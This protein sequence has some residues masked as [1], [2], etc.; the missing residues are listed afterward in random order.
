VRALLGGRQIGQIA[1]QLPV[2]SGLVDVLVENQPEM[3]LAAAFVRIG[4]R[5]IGQTPPEAAFWSQTADLS[6]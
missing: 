6:R 2:W 4:G 5:C 3:C 1:P